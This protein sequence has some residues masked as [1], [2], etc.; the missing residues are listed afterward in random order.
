MSVLRGKE[1]V[2]ETC[3]F[4]KVPTF[5]VSVVSAIVDRL[6]PVTH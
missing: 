1:H 5:S 3:G 6:V 2:L 4:V